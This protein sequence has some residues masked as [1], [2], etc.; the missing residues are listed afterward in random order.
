MNQGYVRNNLTPVAKL[1]NKLGKNQG[2]ETVQGV[3]TDR[4]SAVA[5]SEKSFEVGPAARASLFLLHPANY[6]GNFTYNYDLESVIDMVWTDKW[7]W[8][9]F[10]YCV[11]VC[12][13]V[14]VYAPSC[15]YFKV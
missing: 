8:N 7:P 13:R 10:E 4:L 11:Y 1:Q 2:E 9:Y 3:V 6:D 5:Q 14:R 15:F 12:M